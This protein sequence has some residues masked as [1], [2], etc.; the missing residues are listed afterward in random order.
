MYLGD[1]FA[2]TPANVS[3]KVT[4]IKTYFNQGLLVG[5]WTMSSDPELWSIR[6]SPWSLRVKWA[7]KLLE[8]PYKTVEYIPP[9]GEW[10][11]RLKLWQW[12]VTVPVLFA[13]DVTLKDGKDI[14]KYA[15]DRKGAGCKDIWADP[16][17]EWINTADEI[18]GMMRCAMRDHDALLSFGS[19]ES[20]RQACPWL[21]CRPYIHDGCTYVVAWHRL[22]PA[23]RRKLLPSTTRHPGA[24]I[25][26]CD[27]A[28]TLAPCNCVFSRDL[29]SHRSQ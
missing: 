22:H 7:L 5:V 18:M 10:Q 15:Q 25:S 2:T 17:D 11:L 23:V 20:S 16:V 26:A 4:R 14:V 13:S 8:F 3:S 9:F 1:A 29:H 21:C 6:F 12:R 28:Y 27:Y 19:L 24:G